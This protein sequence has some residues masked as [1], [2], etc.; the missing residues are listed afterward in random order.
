MR[1]TARRLGTLTSALMALVMGGPHARAEGADWRAPTHRRILEGQHWRAELQAGFLTR[2]TERSSGRTLLSVDPGALPQRLPLFGSKRTIDLARCQVTQDILPRSVT[3]ELRCAEG[4]TWRLRWSYEDAS[5]DLVLRASAQAKTPVDELRQLLHGAD[6]VGHELVWV[7]NYGVGEQSHAPWRGTHLGNPETDGSPLTYVHPIVALFAATRGGF[8]VEGREP[9]T[10]PASL[11]LRGEGATATLGFVRRFPVPTLS[12]EMYEIRLRTYENH[13]A[14][15]V[16]PF[17]A[18]MERLLGFV[19]LEKRRSWASRIQNQAYVQV[20]DFDGLNELA[21]RVDPTR[22]LVGREVAYRRHAMDEAYPDYGLTD[23]ARKWFRHARKL[24]FHVGA[25]FNTSGIAR[26][27]T[28]LIERFRA[29]LLSVGR[30]RDGHEEYDGVPGPNRHVYCST[31]FA[32]WR[33]HLIEQMK[34]AVQS[35]V[36]VVYLDESMAP[37]GRFLVDQQTAIEGVM[38]LEREIR[39]A[40]PGVEI[41]VEQLNPMNARGAAFAL[42][43]MPLGHPLGGY[44]FHRF[45]RVVPEGCMYSPRDVAGL[46][47]FARWGFMLPGADA[48]TDEGWL[49]IARA[50]QDLDLHPDVRLPLAEHQLF[51]FRGERGTLAYFERGERSRSF[52]I[53]APGLPARTLAIRSTGVRTWAGP[54]AL[55]DWLFYDEKRLIALDPDATYVFDPDVRPPQ[56]R[57][58]VLRVSEGISLARDAYLD[59][60][61]REVGQELASDGSAFRT[62]LVGRGTL[63]A[64]V[65]DG[66]RVFLDARE[67]VPRADRNVE[68]AVDV[69]ADRP[70]SLLAFRRTG[71]KLSGKLAFLSGSMPTRQ[72]PGH[73]G[74][75]GEDFVAHV[76]GRGFFAGRLPA[77]P[78][79][80]LR[81][82][83]RM[84]DAGAMSVADGV[85]RVNGREVARVPAG[86][87]P[88]KP[89]RFEVDLAPFAGQDVLIELAAEGRVV[90]SG[91]ARW[92]SPE[93]TSR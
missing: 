21:K 7:N 80:R 29:G 55:R 13:W 68:V 79:L 72:R 87:R 18:W 1:T 16:D 76:S 45:V 25:H 75:Q 22:T 81:G 19:A 2:L 5:D 26:S 23:T 92:L 50:F 86:P 44:L 69:S 17:I 40:Y 88:F 89:G 33:R 84:L 46:D 15:A 56:D 4:V 66:Y 67:L 93:L 42:S 36:D 58:H 52:A 20:G 38:A 24:G 35:G 82:G 32:P 31:A 28:K 8:F 41:E 54:G 51:G 27:D 10:G 73:F 43:Q 70:A 53:R 49:Q 71:A 64:F 63:T 61:P 65:P 12:P 85:V 11:M 60:A 74:A 39:A 90:G 59:R 62:R 78:G 6:L 77:S 3:T 48:R 83:Y 91:T 9:R 47:A 37:S 14:D 30:D 57:F 34:E